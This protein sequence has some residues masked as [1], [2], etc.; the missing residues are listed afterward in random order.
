MTYHRVLT[1]LTRW[2]PLVEQELLTLPEHVGS[3]PAFYW[4]S[5]YSIFSLMCTLFVLLSF[6]LAIRLSVLLRYT[7]SDF[8]FGIFKLLSPL[9]L[10]C[11]FLIDSAVF[12]IVYLDI[13]SDLNFQNYTPFSELIELRWEVIIHLADIDGVVVIETNRM[14]Q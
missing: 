1:R 4:G 10:D 9:S 14:A 2:V 3:S 11:L 7:D 8:P 13:Y 12:S 5:C 6:F